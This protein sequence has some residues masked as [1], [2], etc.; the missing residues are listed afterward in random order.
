MIHVPAVAAGCRPTLRTQLAVDRNEIDERA[1]RAKL[2]ESEV[3]LPALDAASEYVAVKREHSLE[4]D[5]PQNEMVDFANAD[6][7][8][9]LA[10]RGD[11][12]LATRSGDQ[13][14][15]ALETFL[16]PILRAVVVLFHDGRVRR[17]DDPGLLRS[18]EDVNVGR[19]AIRLIE[20]AYA[21]KAH[22][23]TCAGV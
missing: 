19:Q 10:H 5:D 14:V 21:N 23:I 7:I 11:G 22:R 16:R 1:P 15:T 8:F 20:R 2:H 4:I 13:S 6:R 9:L 18:G 3:V 12:L 17:E